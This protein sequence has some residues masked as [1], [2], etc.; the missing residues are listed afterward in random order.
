MARPPRRGGIN[1]TD[2][3]PH[4]QRRSE[5]HP[6]QRGQPHGSNMPGTKQ[7]GTAIGKAL[8]AARPPRTHPTAPSSSV[9]GHQGRDAGSPV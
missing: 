1:L 3:R 5:P 7:A 8:G 9:T 6:D 2:K 4:H